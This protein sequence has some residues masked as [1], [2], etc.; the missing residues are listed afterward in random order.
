[1][2]VSQE[3]CSPFYVFSDIVIY[4]GDTDIEHPGTESTILFN[5]NDDVE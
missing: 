3:G 2:P 1:M 5:I 4:E